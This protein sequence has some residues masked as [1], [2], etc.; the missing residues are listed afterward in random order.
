MFCTK[1][2]LEALIWKNQRKTFYMVHKSSKLFS[3]TVFCRA[4]NMEKESILEA[5][6]QAIPPLVE[7]KYKGQAGRIGVVGG[8]KEYTGAPYFAA[9]S[10]LKVGCDLSHVFCTSAASP[11]IKSY[12][13]E[14]IV[15]PLL[16]E[17]D[18]LNEFLQWLPRLHVLVVGPGLGRNSQILSVV[19]V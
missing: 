18:A 16:D 6:K 13:P 8:S 9:I 3:C 15:H 14:L 11:V 12:S 19:K 5:I 1:K 2:G 4:S 7:T 17:V 10:A